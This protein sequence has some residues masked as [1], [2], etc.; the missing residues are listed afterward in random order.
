MKNSRQILKD[1]AVYGA[2]F[3]II[4]A[5]L[6]LLVLTIVLARVVIVAAVVTALIGGTTAYCF[7]LFSPVWIPKDAVDFVIVRQPST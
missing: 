6:P 3:I 7:G 2:T 5:S 1:G 4:A